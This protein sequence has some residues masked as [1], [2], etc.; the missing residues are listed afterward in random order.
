MARFEALIPQLKR[1]RW[2]KQANQLIFQAEGDHSTLE[3]IRFPE[4][5]GPFLKL[6][7]NGLSLSEILQFLHK[8]GTHYRFDRTLEVLQKLVEYRLFENQ[9][10]VQEQLSLFQQTQASGKKVVPTQAPMMEEEGEPDRRFERSFFS[11]ERMIGLLQKTPVFSGCRP[12]IL[13]KVVQNSKLIE[14]Q[15]GTLVIERGTTGTELFVVLSGQLG[16]FQDV[17]T[18]PNQILAVLDTLR[19]FGESAAFFGQKRNAD[20]AGLGHGWVLAIQVPKILNVNDAGDLSNFR[21]LKARVMLNSILAANPLF[22]KVPTDAIQFFL[23]KCELE[24]ASPGKEIVRQG[25]V[26]PWFY[27]IV[28]GEVQVL[29]DGKVVNTHKKGDHFG[30]VGV[31]RG[32]PRAATVVANDDVLLLRLSARH[33]YQVLA[34]NFRLGLHLE[35]A[36]DR[37]QVKSQDTPLSAAYPPPP[38][39]TAPAWFENIE[40]ADF[41]QV[42]QETEPGVYRL[43]LSQP[44]ISLSQID[45]SV[46][47]RQGK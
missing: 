9:M 37:Y 32:E 18:N 7:N 41:N 46:F 35:K 13:Q 28:Q 42:S 38:E 36:A 15:R 5:D 39:I 23:A 27:F 29:K 45:F 25:D 34:E 22:Q 6:L 19:V 1:G 20:V 24:K 21:S 16:V 40:L 10:D 3:R 4:N 2:E 17:H 26:S 8:K 44:D 12:E 47:G 14:F 11:K 43:E 30:E 31:L 33:F